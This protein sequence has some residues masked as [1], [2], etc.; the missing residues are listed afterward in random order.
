MSQWLTPTSAWPLWTVYPLATAC[1]YLNYFFVFPFLAKRRVEQYN[2]LDS[3]NRMCF[4]A[5]LGSTIHS[6]C[7]VVMLFIVLVTDEEMRIPSRRLMPHYNPLGYSAVCFTLAYFSLSL[8]WNM[9]MRFVM[10]RDDV[11]PLPMLA[12]HVMV[13]FGACIYVFSGVCAFYGALAFACMELTNLFFVPR[14]IFEILGWRVDSALCTVNGLLLVVTFVVF[15]IGVT[16]AAAVV[17]TIDI[18]RLGSS[19]STTQWTLIVLA[20]LIF[21]GV[22]LLSWIWLHRVLKECKGGVQALLRQRRAHKAQEAKLKDLKSNAKASGTRASSKV[23]PIDD[24][25][26]NTVSVDVA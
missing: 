5:N 20:Y 7:C 24:G 4:I 14:V 11:V 25:F 12:H 16:S 19:A 22:L 3:V 26:P 21:L 17:F 8:P 2:H 13:V 18:A 6:Y 15:R 10:K 9:Y 23:H 1:F